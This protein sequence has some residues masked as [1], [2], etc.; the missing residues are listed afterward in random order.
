MPLLENKRQIL[1][2]LSQ[3]RRL[4]SIL[5]DKRI[6]ED[7]RED[8]AKLFDV[9]IA[10]RPNAVMHEIETIQS[11]ENPHGPVLRYSVSWENP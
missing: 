7:V 8:Y 9:D 2:L 1:L 5:I 4:L 3:V 10:P 6:P 11:E